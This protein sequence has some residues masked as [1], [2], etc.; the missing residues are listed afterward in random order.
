VTR[1]SNDLQ[2]IFTQ[3]QSN[4]HFDNLQMIGENLLSEATRP[5]S[6][7]PLS[8]G[9]MLRQGAAN[10]QDNLL[11]QMVRRPPFRLSQHYRH[12][13]MVRKPLP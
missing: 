6:Y 7:S 3:S 5:N 4:I 2:I 8:Q 12:N 1:P 10:L 11:G 9:N 13:I